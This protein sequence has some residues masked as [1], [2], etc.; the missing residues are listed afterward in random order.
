LQ[1]LEELKQAYTQA[2]TVHR[3]ELSEAQRQQIMQLV[4][5]F[6]AIWHAETTTAQER[7]EILGLLIKQVAIT[8]VEQPE[9]Q[10][11]IQV[12]WHTGAVSEVS[13]LRPTI[14][15]KLATPEIV[16]QAIRELA[17]GYTDPEIA[18]ILNQ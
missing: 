12:L 13:A 18:R 3:L 9:R 15:Q 2:Q 1:Q 5:D 17:P 11:Q 16:V 8:P 10:T 7:K 14:R 4:Q 6:P